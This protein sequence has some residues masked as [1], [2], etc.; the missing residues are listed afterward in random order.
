MSLQVTS[1]HPY[2]WQ[3]YVPRSD[4]CTS[5][6][7]LQVYVL[8]VTSVRLYTSEKCT[9]LQVTSVCPY[10][11]QVYATGMLL[12]CPGDEFATLQISS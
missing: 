10:K 8:Q 12:F 3:V 2:K 4:K 6:Y 5:L 9:F 11:W 7:K 1:V